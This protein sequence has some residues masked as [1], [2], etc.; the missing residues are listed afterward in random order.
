MST[1]K[2]KLSIDLQFITVRSIQNTIIYLTLLF[3]LLFLVLFF[4]WL[5]RLNITRTRFQFKVRNVQPVACNVVCLPNSVIVHVYQTFSS[6]K[7]K[8]AGTFKIQQ[9]LN[10]QF[11]A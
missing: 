7:M 1:R 8:N 3:F 10:E 5:C 11:I 6:S 4:W 2:V 9:N